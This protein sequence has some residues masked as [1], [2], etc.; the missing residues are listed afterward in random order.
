MARRQTESLHPAARGLDARPDDQIL[1]LLL[2]GQLEALMAVQPAL[3]QI[4]A[5]ARL[6]ADCLRTGGRICYAGAGSSALMANAD[7]MELPGTYGISPDRILL[8]MAGGI[9][10]SPHMPGDTED[11]ATDGIHQATVD[12]LGRGDLVIAVTASGSTPYPMALAGEAR[13]NGARI[14]AVAC[15]RDA[16]IFA[17]ADVAICLATPAELIAGSTRMG[18][19]T[20]QKVTLNLLSTLAAIRLGEVHDGMMVGLT[21]DNAKL[22]ARAA[23]IVG[24]IADVDDG[25]A[26]ESLR[27][28][29]GAVKPAVLMALGITHHQA[30]RLLDDTQGNLR[31]AIA[32]LTEPARQAGNKQS[33]RE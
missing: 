32:R 14:V 25:A 12:G 22:R 5:G 29:D 9:P 18:A 8:R 28:T 20:A 19:G 30:Q 23:A 26:M 16:P 7:G 2:A 11:D 3:P 13:R 15:N 1:P 10:T 21:A 27:Q 24:A 4:A 17:V 31:A 6:M 33:T